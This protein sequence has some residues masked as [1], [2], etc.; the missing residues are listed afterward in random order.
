MFDPYIVPSHMLDIV[1]HQDAH[2]VICDMPDDEL[3][4]EENM[5]DE[6][7]NCGMK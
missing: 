7:I 1:L 3:D 6:Q 4:D 2:Q 5:D